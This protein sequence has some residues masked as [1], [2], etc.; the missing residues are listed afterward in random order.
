MVLKLQYFRQVAG[1]ICR[2]IP[3]RYTS[4]RWIFI[5]FVGFIS[6]FWLS[7]WPSN[8]NLII[9]FSAVYVLWCTLYT[10]HCT[11][12]TVHY[13]SNPL[14]SIPSI[15]TYDHI[16]FE[17]G[18]RSVLYFTRYIYIMIYILYI[19]IYIYIYSKTSL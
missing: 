12:Y 13:T 5:W 19:Y 3:L 11:L 15:H 7:F 6:C 2:G 18:L 16:Y 9:Q 10:L 4:S 14:Y 17:K 8:E 1:N